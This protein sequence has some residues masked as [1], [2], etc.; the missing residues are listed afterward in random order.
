MAAPEVSQERAR[1]ALGEVEATLD[2]ARSRYDETGSAEDKEA[3][4]EAKAQVA[5]ARGSCVC[6]CVCVCVLV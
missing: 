2:G 5:R 1:F 6:V 3:V 4:A